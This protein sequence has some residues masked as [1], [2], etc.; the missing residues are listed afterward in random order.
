[1][2]T[3]KYSDICEKHSFKQATN[4][5]IE[6]DE[7]ISECDINTHK[8]IFTPIGQMA[9]ILNFKNF[10][11]KTSF[12]GKEILVE[13][14]KISPQDYEKMLFEI[15]EKITQLPFD[16]NTPTYEFF[17]IRD[18]DNN[19]IIYHTF[20]ILRYIFFNKTENLESAYMT[21]FNNPNKKAER[22]TC[23]S[24]IWDIKNVSV[25]TI[26]SIICH[27]DC[28]LEMGHTNPLH[29][30][31]LAK[32][33]YD[34]CNNNYFPYIAEE[35]KVVRSL[36][37]PE[38]RFIK[39]FLNLCIELIQRFKQIIS[40]ET[41]INK[42]ELMNE[43]I[44][45]QEHLENL[46]YNPLFNEVGDID[47]IPFNSMVMQ[48]REGYKNILHYYNMLHSAISI[49]LSEKQMELIQ[50]KDIAELYEIWTYFKLMDTI[51]KCLKVKPLKAY[52]AKI[53]NFKAI[54]EY[55]INVTYRFN[56]E[57]IKLWYNKTYSKGKGSYSVTLRPD[58]V[59]EIGDDKYIFD[60]KFK[61]ES[62]NWN[63]ADEEEE[64][65][66]KKADIY[67]M[68]T[69]KDAIQGVKMACILY[70]NP[71]DDFDFFEEDEG[72]GLGIGA[73]PLKPGQD[74]TKLEEFLKYRCFGI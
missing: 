68:H 24:Y 46:L 60:A 63:D 70:P 5:A 13:S 31:Q 50:N 38:N 15:T 26:N 51:E 22:E 10:M 43:C 41:I 47:R 71:Q 9:G 64:F 30:N 27:P 45:M 61:L 35:T 28:L 69:Y 58:V 8:G 42:I 49:P 4:Y 34:R 66:F 33:I 48:K 39:Y 21:V 67:K 37:T 57:D 25:N 19:E 18:I 2:E 12:L 29:N 6:F 32:K 23:Q 55:S 53:D 11:G 36:D 62:I 17:D 59:L 74:Y 16:F 1:M 20:L 72:T 56:N 7:V 3:I 14:K 52:Y 40:M 65:T 44:I 73:I 54:V